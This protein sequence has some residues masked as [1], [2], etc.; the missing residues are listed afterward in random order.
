VLTGGS[1][2]EKLSQSLPDL[3]EK[4][5]KKGM[6]INWVQGPFSDPPNIP[7]DSHLNWKIHKAPSGL[8]H[9][10]LKSNYVLTLFG[11]SLFEVMQY[12]VPAVVFSPYKNRDD[13]DLSDLSSQNVVL[14]AESASEAVARLNALMID[15]ELAENL[16]YE[17]L[18]KLATNGAVN[19]ASQIHQLLEV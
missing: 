4:T 18:K 7:T 9:L 8:D 12:G 19:L 16:S 2:V 17:S 10:I 11:I 14:V 13:Q 5:L 3:L 1:D 15:D 6:E